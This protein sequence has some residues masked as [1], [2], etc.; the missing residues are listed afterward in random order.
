MV[1]STEI[2]NI[3]A[4]AKRN[5]QAWEDIV[6]EDRHPTKGGRI[7]AK[8]FGFNGIS[9]FYN[10]VD[11]MTSDPDLCKKVELLIGEN[12]YC[13]YRAMKARQE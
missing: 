6:E 11:A 8:L 5:I 12:G 2:W 10:L 3:V 7:L 13:L 4:I 9:G 1:N